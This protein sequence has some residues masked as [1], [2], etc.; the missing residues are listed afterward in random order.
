M[1]KKYII[2]TILIIILLTIIIGVGYFLIPKFNIEDFSKSITLNYDEEYKENHGN[3]CYG[4]FIS[5]KEVKVLTIGEVDTTSLGEYNVK[6]IYNY[7]DEQ[8]ILNQKVNVVDSEK[9]TIDIESEYA[10]VCPSGKIDNLVASARDN[11]DKDLTDKIEKTYE[12]GKV[13]LKVEDSSGNIREEIIDAKVEDTTSPVITL[14]GKETIYL[15]VGEA[16]TEEGTTVVDNCDEVEVTIEGAV[17]T[18]TAGTYIIKY[19]AVDASQNES[20]IERTVNVYNPVYGSRIIYLTFDDGPSAYTARLLDVLKKYNV[21]ATFFVTGYGSDEMILREYE[22]GHAIGL[23]TYTHDYSQ[24]YTSTDAFFSDL[25]A[26][27]ERVKNITG[28]T[29]YL[30]R[31][32]GG[33]SNMVSA[34]YDGGVHIMSTLVDEVEKRGFKYFDW[35]VSSGDAGA[36]YSS[37]EVYYNVTA[38]LKE[39]YSVVLQHDVKSFS[40]DA[41]ESIVQYALANGYRFEKLDMSSPGAHHGVNN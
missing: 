38:T 14:N 28:H 11:Y 18:S 22:E 37:D 40:V 10:L 7:K 17:D 25:Y 31:F 12:D 15:K 36:A 29:T 35:N 20:V 23:H 8:L 39:E 6:Y 5:C 19:K 2:L 41:V 16:Y 24:I 3:I 13:Y 26:V 30:M 21:K 27:Q 32:A 9:P 33:S 4:N 1:K 34:Y